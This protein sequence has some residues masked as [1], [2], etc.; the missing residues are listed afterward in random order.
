VLNRQPTLEG[1]RLVLRP[2]RADDWDA[3]YAVAADPLIW[4]QHPAH[5]RW[6]EEVFRAF[7]DDAL[8]QGGALVVIAKPSCQV[9]GSSRF[10]GFEAAHGGSIE[11]GW[12]FLARAY[13][14]GS[15]NREMKRLMLEHA[16]ASVA[17]C[18]FAVGETNWRSR[19]ALE[20]IGGQL[21]ERV[22]ERIMA[23]GI[24]R[25]IHYTITADDFA[26]SA[27]F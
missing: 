8:A 22:D 20:K 27:M 14:G 4:E 15:V 6:R 12:T 17:E 11:I 5:D 9:I 1:E 24:V 7:F 19:R 3:L 16:L 26:R 21:S 18:R 2:L 10:Q 23:G 13:W 25:H